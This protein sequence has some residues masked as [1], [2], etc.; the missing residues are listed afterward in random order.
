MNGIMHFREAF[1][2]GEEIS[3]IKTDSPVMRYDIC[4]DIY[5]PLSTFAQMFLFL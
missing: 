1:L 2:E 5:L 3:Q 4:N